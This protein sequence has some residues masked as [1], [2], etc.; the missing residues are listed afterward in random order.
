MKKNLVLIHGRHYKPKKKVLQENWVEALSYGIARDYG[1]KQ[2]RKFD[3]I[4]IDFVYFGDISNAFLND[5]EKKKARKKNIEFNKYNE[6][7]DLLDRKICLEKLKEYKKEDFNK[8]IYG[9]LPGKSRT[10]ELLAD[11]FAGILFFFRL[12]KKIIPW[13][14]PDMDNYWNKEAEF[15]SRVRFRL[16]KVLR[17]V[18]KPGND[19]MLIGHSLGSII[20]YDVLWEISHSALYGREGFNLQGNNISKFVSLGC[21]LGDETV[22]RNLK[23]ANMKSSRKYPKNIKSWVNIAAVDD[24]ISHDEKVANDYHTMEKVYGLVDSIEDIRIYNLAVRETK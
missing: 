5:S 14:A 7:T 6:K 15:G 12:S 2:Q 19:V 1:A 22:K 4:K 13:K 20:S 21:P 18:M 3:K 17:T 9:K 10:K 11:M 16:S 23:G 24:H 8:K